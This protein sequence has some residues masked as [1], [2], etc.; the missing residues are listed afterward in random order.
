VYFGKLFFESDEQEFSLRG[1][2]S[3]KISR[4]ADSDHFTAFTTNLLLSSHVS[5][6]VNKDWI[7][8]DKDQ[9]LKDNGKD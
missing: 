2:K 5:S 8:K 7:H 1:V 3:K 4:L 9:A 6:D